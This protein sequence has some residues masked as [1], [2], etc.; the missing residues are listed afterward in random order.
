[1]QTWCTAYTIVICYFLY[2]YD[3]NGDGILEFVLTTTDAEILFVQTDNTLLHGETI[4]VPTT[5]IH[6][7]YKCPQAHSQIFNVA[8]RKLEVW[9]WAWGQETTT[10]NIEELLGWCSGTCTCTCTCVDLVYSMWLHT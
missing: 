10:I 6:V 1:M 7:P 5:Y 2:Q 4:K 9:E 8:Y 3:L